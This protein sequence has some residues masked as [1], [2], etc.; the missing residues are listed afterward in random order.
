MTS[1]VI[2]RG[3]QPM[4]WTRLDALGVG[5]IL[6]NKMPHQSLLTSRKKRFFSELNVSILYILHNKQIITIEKSMIM[7]YIRVTWTYVTCGR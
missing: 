4:D 7:T 6:K 2:G 1:M 5:G 3:V